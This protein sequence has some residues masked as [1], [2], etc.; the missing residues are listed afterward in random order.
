MV[1]IT[2]LAALLMVAACASAPAGHADPVKSIYWTDGDSGRADGVEF[3]LADV[4]AP[5]TGGVG[6]RGGA[7]C[8]AERVRG[9]KAKEFIVAATKGKALAITYNGEVD[10]WGRRVATVTASGKDVGAAGIAA[11]HLKPYVFDGRRS[12]MPKPKWCP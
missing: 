8:E 7:K 9:F 6:S 11:G 4:D 12:T 2:R 1:R 3:R 5:E 10:T